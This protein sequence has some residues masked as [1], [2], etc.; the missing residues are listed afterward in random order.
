MGQ[1]ARFI[2]PTTGHRRQITTI[3]RTIEDYREQA[4]NAGW[5]LFE[6]RSLVVTAELGETLPRALPYVGQNLGWAAFWRQS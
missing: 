6:E 3:H 4:G 1:R 5:V 2:D